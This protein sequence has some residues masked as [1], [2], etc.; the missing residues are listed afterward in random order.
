MQAAVL[1]GKPQQSG[2]FRA[3]AGVIPVPDREGE[4]H[5]GAFV[6]GYVHAEFERETSWSRA[7]GRK[8]PGNVICK[9]RSE[10]SNVR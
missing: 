4:R 8:A 2:G 9:F 3:L 1:S 7:A 5:K 10:I 6:H